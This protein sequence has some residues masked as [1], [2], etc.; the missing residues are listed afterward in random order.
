MFNFSDN[1][2]TLLRQSGRA[3]LVVE[4]WIEDQICQVVPLDAEV[5]SKLLDDYTPSFWEDPSDNLY[6]ATRH[7]RIE[8]FKR[9]N[10]LLQV[11]EYFSRTRD[12][13][14]QIVF[15]MIRT[16]S[17]SRIKELLL[18]IREGD[19]DFAAAAIRWSEGP[20]SARGGRVG[21]IPAVHAG[22]PELRRRLE[23][24]VEGQYVGPFTIDQTNV[25]LRLD[26][27]IKARL[28]DDM[29]HLILE[30]LYHNWMSRQISRL[31]SGEI[32]DP[33]EYLP[34]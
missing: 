12:Q 20:E 34:A 19:L 2:W 23:Y 33:I 17:S 25:V 11:E 13:R 26:K 1:S 9:S 27:R 15:S 16:S 4:A 18:A 7:R 22:H 31:E 32:M 28:D 6:V 8:E 30:E 14:E 5:E 3:R 29:Q 10:F 21:P 24:A